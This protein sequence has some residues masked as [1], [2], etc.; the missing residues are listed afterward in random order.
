MQDL[1]HDKYKFLA[2]LGIKAENLGCYRAGEWVGNGAISTSVNP[3]N[4]KQ[5]ASTKMASVEDYNSCIKAM[6]E[7]RVRWA[8]LPTP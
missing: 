3:S 1:T 2:D 4:N 7:E 6:E 8:K 5:I